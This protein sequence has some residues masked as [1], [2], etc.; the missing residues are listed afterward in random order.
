MMKVLRFTNWVYYLLYCYY[1]AIFFAFIKVFDLLL[2]HSLYAIPPVR[3]RLNEK[4]ISRE[5]VTT[6]S[7]SG[8]L[9]LIHMADYGLGVRLVVGG[10]LVIS[11]FERLLEIKIHRAGY[12]WPIAAIYALGVLV[13]MHYSIHRKG[14]F[15]HYFRCF[16]NAPV[17]TKVFWC[18][19]VHVFFALAFFILNI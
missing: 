15:L 14:I 19:V 17:R 13:F 2:V 12:F 11:F 7:L 6:S 4:G 9:R 16:G 8:D 10:Y 3:R 1:Y 5:S 18:M